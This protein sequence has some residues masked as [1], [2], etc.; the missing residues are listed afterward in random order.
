M[1]THTSY[2]HVHNNVT[3]EIRQNPQS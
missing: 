3:L 2:T 1:T